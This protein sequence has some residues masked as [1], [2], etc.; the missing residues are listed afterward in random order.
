MS[1]T[2]EIGVFHR[3]AVIANIHAQYRSTIHEFAGVHL[4]KYELVKEGRKWVTKPT[5]TYCTANNDMSIW[6]IP[7]TILPKFKLYLKSKGITFRETQGNHHTPVSVRMIKKTKFEPRDSQPI[8]IDYMND[9]AYPTKLIELQT[10]QGKTFCTYMSFLHWQLRSLILVPKM[11]L[12]RWS[13]DIPGNIGINID[14]R[15]LLVITSGKELRDLFRYADTPEYQNTKIICMTTGTMETYINKFK[16]TYRSDEYDVPPWEFMA[17]LGIGIKVVDEIHKNFHKNMIIDLW[18]NH[19]IGINL[20]ATMTNSDQQQNRF[21]EIFF[22]RNIRCP[23]IPYVKYIDVKEYV[24]HMHMNSKL[25]YIQPGMNTYSHARLELSIKKSTRSLNRWLLMINDIAHKEYFTL[26]KEGDKLLILCSTR[27]MVNLIYEE[28]K[29]KYP[30]ELVGRYLQEDPMSVLEDNDI[31][32]STEKSAGTAVD[33]KG[34]ITAILTVAIESRQ[35]SEQCLGRTRE[36]KDNEEERYP[37]FI[38]MTCIDIPKHRDY[39]MSKQKYFDDKC[40]S[41]RTIHSG[42]EL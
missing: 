4:T 31:I 33:I 20:S 3:F 10:G 9:P 1:K 28:M 21:Y 40:R 11:Y 41:F 7:L 2:I 15:E 5:Y 26:R 35:A 25:S 17:K 29:A 42:H 22:P 18:L 12:E 19:P 34:L 27:L 14:K 13:D 24:Y 39:S 38:Y 36:I 30:D 8:V 32:V 23:K 16:G 6:R 37:R